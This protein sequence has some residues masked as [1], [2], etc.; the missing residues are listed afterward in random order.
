MITA[1]ASGMSGQ[2][3]T[4][5]PGQFFSS[6]LYSRLRTMYYAVAVSSWPVYKTF[7]FLMYGILAFFT[8]GALKKAEAD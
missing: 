5:G 7:V 2:F 6:Y 3:F 4:T 1:I 8:V